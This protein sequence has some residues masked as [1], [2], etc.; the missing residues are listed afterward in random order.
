MRPPQSPIAQRQEPAAATTETAKPT[1]AS[2]SHFAS[3]VADGVEC[4]RDPVPEE[5]RRRDGGEKGEQK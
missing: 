4:R 5:L 1:P 2:Q 3:A